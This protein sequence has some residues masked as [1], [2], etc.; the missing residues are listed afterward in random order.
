MSRSIG[1]LETSY[2]A[3]IYLLGQPKAQMHSN[4]STDLKYPVGHAGFRFPP[5]DDFFL[6]VAYKRS[7]QEETVPSWKAGVR[8]AKSW[9]NPPT[10]FRTR[11]FSATHFQLE[12]ETHLKYM[13]PSWTSPTVSSVVGWFGDF[14]E[15]PP[16]LKSDSNRSSSAFKGTKGS[17]KDCI[18]LEQMAYLHKSKTVLRWNLRLPSIGPD[19][20]WPVWLTITGGQVVPSNTTPLWRQ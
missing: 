12:H 15:T 1:C 2:P 5:G 19:S 13:G 10:W 14:Y 7:S 16:T 18:I 8:L 3:V 9:L 17:V 11:T 20:D 4:L 6:P